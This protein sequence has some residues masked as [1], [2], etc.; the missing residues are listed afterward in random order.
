VE[1]LVELDSGFHLNGLSLAH[2]N[3]V[4]EDP[5]VWCDGYLH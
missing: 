3:D 2:E 4:M 5:L 1:T